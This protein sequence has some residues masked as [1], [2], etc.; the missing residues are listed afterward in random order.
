MS[1]NFAL[2]LAADQHG[3][4]ATLDRFEMRHVGDHLIHRYPPEYSAEHAAD[5]H[6]G[7][8]TARAQISVAI[9][10]RESG[11]AHRARCDKAAAV[12]QGCPTRNGFHQA[13]ST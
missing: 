8:I 7:A 2:A 4:I 11:D 5:E 12:A 10:G 13:H 9:T 3:F 1:G 6:T